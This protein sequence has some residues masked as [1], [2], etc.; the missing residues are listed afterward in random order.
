MFS[1]AKEHAR[2]KTQTNNKTKQ[3][4]ANLHLSRCAAVIHSKEESWEKLRQ[5]DSKD[6]SAKETGNLD[7]NVF[8]ASKMQKLQGTYF[9]EAEKRSHNEKFQ[10]EAAESQIF[11]EPRSN[12]GKKAGQQKTC[13]LDAQKC[14][15]KVRIF[16]QAVLRKAK[17]DHRYD[18]STSAMDWPFPLLEIKGVMM[19]GWRSNG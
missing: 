3:G 18:P 15:S 19:H 12:R 4:N 5:P 14:H 7:G 11:K 10:T 1:G 2:K 16:S 13:V 8:F 6:N 9:K 17:Q